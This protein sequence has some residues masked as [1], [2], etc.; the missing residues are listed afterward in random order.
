MDKSYWALRARSTGWI[1]CWPSVPQDRSPR[2]VVALR[3]ASDRAAKPV[4]RSAC[5]SSVL[6]ELRVAVFGVLLVSEASIFAAAACRTQL[7]NVTPFLPSDD[8]LR[9]R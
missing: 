4:V 6:R 8:A 1:S 7:G 5:V 3:R 9:F 2:D